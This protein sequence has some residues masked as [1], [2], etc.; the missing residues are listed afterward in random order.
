MTTSTREAE[1]TYT[2]AGSGMT[3]RCCTESRFGA[4]SAAQWSSRTTLP[5]NC[6]RLITFEPSTAVTVNSGCTGSEGTGV[7]LI[8]DI[9]GEGPLSPN[10]SGHDA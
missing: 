6:E 8:L 10:G 3:W 1:M 4:G 7:N 9:R 5:R 2:P